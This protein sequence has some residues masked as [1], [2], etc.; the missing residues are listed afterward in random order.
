MGFESG[1]KT[2]L[3]KGKDNSSKARNFFAYH[4]LNLI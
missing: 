1:Y 3:I 4:Y 2:V